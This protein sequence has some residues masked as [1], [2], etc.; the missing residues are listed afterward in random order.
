MSHHSQEKP[1]QALARQLATIIDAAAG[2]YPVISIKDGPCPCL[3]WEYARIAFIVEIDATQEGA[4]FDELRE[5]I[6]V[7]SIALG[8]TLVAATEAIRQGRTEPYLQ[9][10][11]FTTAGMQH[12]SLEWHKSEAMKT[13]GSKML[14]QA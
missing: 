12:P 9:H 8:I 10:R 13:C 6:R 4:Q 11:P 3:H 1:L 5:T 2:D 14:N 7:N